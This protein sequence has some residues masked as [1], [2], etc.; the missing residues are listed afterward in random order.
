[1]DFFCEQA[2]IVIEADGAPHFPPRR[3]QRVR[4]Y[5]LRAAGLIVLRF[6]NYEILHQTDRVLDRIRQTL[7]QAAPL[8]LRERGRG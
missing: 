6:W 2:G 7:R 5:W 4:D 3:A 8:S 1:V